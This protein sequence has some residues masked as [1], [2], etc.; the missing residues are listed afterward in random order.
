MRRGLGPCKSNEAVLDGGLDGGLIV[1]VDG[2]IL[3]YSWIVSRRGSFRLEDTAPRYKR[4]PVHNFRVVPPMFASGGGFIAYLENASDAFRSRFSFDS[5]S[6][7]IY[8]PFCVIR[9][10]SHTVRHEGSRY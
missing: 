6:C 7:Y 4:Y 10:L 5:S 3:R 8:I 2:V 9:Q 1:F